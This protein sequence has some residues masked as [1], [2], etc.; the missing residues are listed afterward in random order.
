[1]PQVTAIQPQKKKA[2]RFN[3][4]LDG[5]FAFGLDEATLVKNQI[6]VNQHLTSEQ[7][8]KIIKEGELGK[9]VDQS[10]RFLSY[11][12]RSEKEVDDFLVQK[13]AK[14]EKIKYSQAKQS[15][16]VSAVIAKLKR[17][18]YLND[19][20]FARWWLRARS[21]VRPRGTFL[22][23]LELARKGVAKE[24]I[25]EVLLRAPDQVE[26]AKKVVLKKMGTWRNLS[27]QDLRKKVYGH[28]LVRGFDFETVKKTLAFLIEKG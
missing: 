27:E 2:K 21:G 24:I 22:I 13:I 26:L 5:D 16:L 19:L 18:K 3:I 17:Y 25:E 28:L 9:L 23:K 15:T 11:R 4:F 1:M 10:L 8:E 20:E 6:M 7:V 12:P 14:K